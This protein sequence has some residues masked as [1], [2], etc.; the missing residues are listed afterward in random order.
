MDDS[1]YHRRLAAVTSQIHPPESLYPSMERLVR[2]PILSNGAAGRRGG[3]LRSPSI[4]A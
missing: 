2:S 1:R 3:N 4:D